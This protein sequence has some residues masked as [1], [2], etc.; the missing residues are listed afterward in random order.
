VRHTV[1]LAVQEQYL[2]GPTM[3]D[4]WDHARRMGFDATEPPIDTS[5]IIQPP[6]HAV[7]VSSM[8]PRLG[9]RGLVFAERAYPRLVDQNAYI[10][11]RRT[12][13]GGLAALVHPLETGLDN[14]P[15][16][17]HPL[18][19]VPAD[20]KLL[21]TYTRRDVIHAGA[22]ERPTDE[23]YARYIRLMLRYRDHGYDDDWVRAEAAFCVVD[24]AFN[25]LCVRVGSCSSVRWPGLS[26]WCCRVCH[27]R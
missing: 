21:E 15:A 24:P 20:L 4:K 1:P 16:W 7:A 11:R 2:R 18:A 5:G 14:S 17:D 25:T 12:V 9:E 8:V 6:L 23:N 27:G 3:I 22:G 10:R 13:N 26:R 19:A